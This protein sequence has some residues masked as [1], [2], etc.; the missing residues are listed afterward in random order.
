MTLRRGWVWWF[1]A[2][3][4]VLLCLLFIP[5]IERFFSPFTFHIP[6]HF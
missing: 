4:Y 1:A 2:I 6:G 5:H 3:V